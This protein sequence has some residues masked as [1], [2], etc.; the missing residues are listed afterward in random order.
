MKKS[1][2]IKLIV[3]V[4]ALLSIVALT[5]CPQPQRPRLDYMYDERSDLCFAYDGSTGVADFD[6]MLLVPCSDK[7]K[8]AAQADKQK[9]YT[10]DA[11]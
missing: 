5:G 10:Q 11:D 1:I 4:L 7:V 3:G 6:S 9:T 2:Y 8:A